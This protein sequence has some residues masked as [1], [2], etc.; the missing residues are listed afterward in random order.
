MNSF[1]HLIQPKKVSNL[2]HKLERGVIPFTARSNFAHSSKL[3]RI[4]LFEHI[5]DFDL[6]S[7]ETL[8]IIF[9][10][11]EK[12][13]FSLLFINAI[14]MATLRMKEEN[15]EITKPCDSD[16]LGRSCEKSHSFLREFQGFVLS[17]VISI[18]HLS[19]YEKQILN[20]IIL[21]EQING[22]R[23]Q[24]LAS[25]FKSLERRGYIS[26]VNGKWISNFNC[27]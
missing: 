7:V 20:H 21:C 6:I 4:N 25:C 19:F 11:C 23:R 8:I 14:P 3:N 10:G 15:I 12:N 17:D 18:N 5:S 24:T 26:N 27:D 16:A 2:S 22:I 1:P 13:N 9:Y